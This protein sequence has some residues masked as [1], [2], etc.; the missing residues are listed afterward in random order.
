MHRL[1][2]GGSLAAIA[3]LVSLFILFSAGIGRASPPREAASAGTDPA[4]LP[5]DAADPVAPKSAIPVLCPIGLAVNSRDELFVGNHWSG[6]GATPGQVLVFDEDGMQ[7]PDRT[8]TAG[9]FNPTG[10]AFDADDNLYVSDY[11]KQEVRV[12]N[13]AGKPLLGKTLHTDKSYNPAGVQIDSRGDVWVANRT[14]ENIT[15]G[16]VEIFHK[17]GGVDKITE[18]LVYPL[19][20]VFQAKT[21][22]AWVGNA[23][24]PAGEAFTIFSQDGRFLDRIPTPN[25]LPTYLA[26]DL[27][28]GRL[29]ATDA[30]NSLVEIFSPSGRQI[31][32]AITAGLDGPYGI[33]FDSAGDFFVANNSSST[34]TKYSPSGRLLCTITIS[35]CK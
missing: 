21:G 13:P 3:A 26:F 6:C 12:Y 27:T 19:G 15:L 20:I 33:A 29:Y 30:A 23:E 7:L 5:G 31:G 32:S 28:N 17:G 8:I 10:L 11:T 24:Y 14:N 9:L 22:N 18:G 35:G 1:T 2:G 16:E 4:A 34:L 25:F